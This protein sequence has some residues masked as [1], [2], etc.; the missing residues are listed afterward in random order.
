MDTNII[1]K[2]RICYFDIEGGCL[3]GIIFSCTND[4]IVLEKHIL[5]SFDNEKIISEP[6]GYSTDIINSYRK[7]SIPEINRFIQLFNK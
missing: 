7:A 2:K 4:I 3:L 5:Y 6:A 1:D